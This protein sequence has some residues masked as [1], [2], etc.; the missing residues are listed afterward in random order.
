MKKYLKLMRVHHWI[1]NFLVLLPVI[2]NRSLFHVKHLEEVGW[3]FLSISF[4]ASVV[5]ILNDIKDCEKDR[6]HPTKK[7]RPIASGAV[8]VP[9]ALVLGILLFIIAIG[10]NGYFLSWDGIFLLLLYFGLNV[11]YSNG[12]KNVPIA[13]I[14]ILVSGFLIRVFYG[15]SITGI[16]V[17]DWLY[18]TIIAVSFYFGLGKRRNE[19]MAAGTGET[20]KVLQYYTKDF[21]D[22]NMYLCLAL[23]IVFY[24]L[25]T[26]ENPNNAM[27]WTVP[28]VMIICMKYN[29]D[30]EKGYDGDPVE[31]LF[32]DKI[33]IGLSMM[34]AIVVIGLL[35]L[36]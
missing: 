5:Y 6:L 8:T 14:T 11:G 34:Y 9:Q 27:V 32:K 25:W 7:N 33:L 35:Y 36:V 13:D 28:I 24:A 19:I 21:L 15:A 3:G 20:R 26:I 16:Q 18:L 31:V 2:F 23:G 12:L 29:L 17:S 30:L 10:I 1:K 4:I 22:K